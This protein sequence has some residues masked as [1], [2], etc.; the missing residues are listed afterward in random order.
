M[1]ET[2][3]ETT[4]AVAVNGAQVSV[5]DAA[6]ILND[7]EVGAKDS[8][9]LEMEPGEERRV[10]FLGWEEIDGMGDRAG[11]KVP[12]ASFVTNEGKKQINADAVIVSYFQKQSQGCARR[13]VCT[14]VARSKNGFDY[15]KFDFYEIKLKAV[16]A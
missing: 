16:K 9:Y 2:K 5:A 15:K 3:E 13:I 10:V 12:A 8:N 1:T 7:A 14:G 4:N 6:A 11:Q